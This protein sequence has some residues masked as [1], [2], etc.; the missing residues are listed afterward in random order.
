MKFETG[1]NRKY[2]LTEN[3][4]YIETSKYVHFFGM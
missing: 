1:F 2:N 3:T 4:K